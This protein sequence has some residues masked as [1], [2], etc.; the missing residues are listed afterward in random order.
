L[1]EA[2]R[3]IRAARMSECGR[4][5]RASCNLGFEDAEVSQAEIVCSERAPPTVF[6]E[7]IRRDEREW[8]VSSIEHFSA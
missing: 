3:E 2:E 7:A 8:H 4:I 5:V 6:G 1:I